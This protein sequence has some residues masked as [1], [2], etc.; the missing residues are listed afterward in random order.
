MPGAMFIVKIL[1]RSFR[2]NCFHISY[3]VSSS[4]KL[5]YVT[6]TCIYL[7]FFND[8]LINHNFWWKKLFPS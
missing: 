1:F 8:T 2:E 4:L 6:S 5:I 7:P 3:K